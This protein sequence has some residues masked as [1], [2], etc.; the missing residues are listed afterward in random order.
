MGLLTQLLLVRDGL[1]FSL[2]LQLRL[3]HGFGQDILGTGGIPG[4]PVQPSFFTDA[5][6]PSPAGSQGPRCHLLVFTS[7]SPDK[8]LTQLVPPWLLFSE[9]LEL[10]TWLG[11]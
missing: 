10:Y 6:P 1:L 4:L 11:L 7:V 2:R 9:D 3:P 8:S 5:S